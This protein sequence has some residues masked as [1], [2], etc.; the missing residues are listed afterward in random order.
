MGP[1]VTHFLVWAVP[2]QMYPCLLGWGQGLV[3]SATKVS[4]ERMRWWGWGRSRSSCSLPL[5][6]S[7]QDLTLVGSEGQ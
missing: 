1:D 2:L 3:P 4:L 5:E 7:G 6:N